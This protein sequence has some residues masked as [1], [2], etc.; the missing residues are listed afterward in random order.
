MQ[1]LSNGVELG[2]LKKN[3][4]EPSHQLAMV[5]AEEKQNRVLE[6]SNENYLK[7][8]HGEALRT[9]S[10]ETGFVLVSYQNFILGFGKISNH[11]I[12]NYYPKGLR[13]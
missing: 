8:L 5:L 12:K 3:R 10:N 13:V 2:L 7:H 9:E 1:I 11:I 4:F 6:L